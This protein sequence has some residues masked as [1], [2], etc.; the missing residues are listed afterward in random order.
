[1]FTMFNPY[2]YATNFGGNFQVNMMPAYFSPCQ[3]YAIQNLTNPFFYFNNMMNSCAYQT[4]PMQNYFN[5]IAY[6]QGAQM[7]DSIGVNASVQSFG[8]NIATFK[9]DMQKGSESEKLNETQKQQLKEVLRELEQI[10]QEYATLKQLQQMANPQQVKAGLEVLLNKFNVL[11]EKAQKLSDKI[12][13]EIEQTQQAAGAHTGAQDDTEET[14][15]TDEDSV[16]EKPNAFAVKTFT[17]KID[18]AIFGVGTNYDSDEDGLKP[19][20]EQIDANSVIEVWNQWD[21]TYGTQGR[22][23]RDKYGFIETLMDDCEGK[24]KETIGTYLADALEQRAYL[25]GIDADKEVSAARLSLKSNWLG[26]RNDDKI[27]KALI[28]LKNKVENK[29]QEEQQVEQ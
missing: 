17:H 28:E 6:M 4:N 5:P 15:T 26:F 24:Q 7:G 8:N 23:A 18:K 21:S 29:P 13:T 19:L 2:L 12:L 20:M 1:M 14:E 10:E 3:A 9:A 27:C 22:Y 16:L 25:L 11:K